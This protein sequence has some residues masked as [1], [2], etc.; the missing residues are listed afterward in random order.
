MPRRRPPRARRRRALRRALVA[1]LALAALAVA[2]SQLR[3]AAA[4][5]PDPALDG[6]RLAAD[7]AGFAHDVPLDPASPW[8]K[9]RG[10]ARQS[11]RSALRPAPSERAPWIFPTGQG[12]FSPPVVGGDG[13][14]YVGSADHAFYAIDADGALRWRFE[15]GGVID[16]AALLDDR[17]RVFVPSGDGHLHA[18]D[19]ATG[20]AL[21]AFRAHTPAEVA[22]LHGIEV[23]NVDWWEGHVALLPDGTLLAGND[24]Y[25][26]YLLDRETGEERGHLLGNELAWSLPAVNARTGRIFLGTMFG[27]LRNLFAFDP[28]T[29]ERL[30][31]TGALGPVASSPLLTT[32]RAD[33]ALV[34]GGFDGF[35]RAFD[36]ARGRQLWRFATRDHVY[37]SAAQLSDGTLV[38]PSTDG[39]IYA[40]DPERGTRVWAF[41]TLAP[42]RASPAI[43]GDDR[44]YVGTGDGRLLALEP[45]GTL[46]WAYR[47]IEGDRDDLNGSPGL[48]PEGVVAGGEDGSVCFVPYDHCLSARGRSD[49]RCAVGGGEGLPADGAHLLFT[50]RFGGL[51]REPPAQIDA[52]EPLAF[53]LSVRAGGDTELARI[54]KDDLAV[55]LSTGRAAVQVSAD[56]RFVT[57]VPEAPWAGPAGGRLLVELRGSYRVQ[58]WR[59]GLRPFGGRD[60]GR[61]SERFAFAVR[62]RPRAAMPYAVPRAPGEPAA[63]FSLGRLAAPNPTMLPS[64][65]QIGF[66]SLRYLGG[67]VEGDE[68]SAL[69]WW[70][71]GRRGADGGA[72]VDP[73]SATRFVLRLA[74]D[75]GLVTLADDAGFTLDFAGSWA[76]PTR[77]YRLATRAAPDGRIE[78][79][80]A[81]H[82]V[83]DCGRIARYGRFLKLLGLCEADTGW[84]HVQ[85]GAE[86][87]VWEPPAPP[88]DVGEVSFELGPREAIARLAGGHVAA[89]AHAV[90]LLLV[91]A[92]SGEPVPLSYGLATTVERDAQGAATAVRMRY[93]RGTI[94]GPVRAHLLVDTA[95]VATAT[96]PAP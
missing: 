77:S 86:L 29:G 71:G 47:C 51:L 62:P 78:R 41:D 31:A 54:E 35:V 20:R 48:G 19:R 59:L 56:R 57:I 96:L 34:V 61:F 2:A 82:V 80:A 75:D 3:R 39:T 22:A 18:L 50:T 44:I 30:W 58:P 83:V 92:A 49:R 72:E 43:D 52:N 46:R 84:M 60:G 8:P 73:A 94:R 67:T 1:A 95:L 76:M 16:S 11:G 90:G 85:G 69:V 45:D 28:A 36:Q 7:G 93:D 24:N 21:W 70:V 68:R 15:T 12:V 17:G 66:D 79:P 14:V 65:N 4:M 6:P 9:F 63:A 88:A 55:A 37:A 13:T 25:L 33:G 42:I 27:A 26:V 81:L 5:R 53:T 89:A 23:F 32:T 40:L 38:V 10:D 74:W 64:W 87:A 91:D